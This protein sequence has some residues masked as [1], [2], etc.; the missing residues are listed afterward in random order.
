MVADMVLMK[1]HLVLPE[2]ELQPFGKAL[3]KKFR[4]FLKLQCNRSPINNPDIKFLTWTWLQLHPNQQQIISG[5]DDVKAITEMM[6]ALQVHPTTLK[7][8]ARPDSYP[9]Y[10][11]VDNYARIVHNV[12]P[13]SI[14]RLDRNVIGKIYHDYYS[15]PVYAARNNLA[16]HFNGENQTDVVDYVGEYAVVSQSS[17]ERIVLTKGQKNWQIKA[18]HWLWFDGD[19]VL[20]NGD[21]KTVLAARLADPNRLGFWVKPGEYKPYEEHLLCPE[22]EV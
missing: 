9:L 18:D 13:K 17:S 22:V 4:S 16:L 12:T 11:S 19:G 14:I 2:E 20:H 5:F 10:W 7:E 3:I 21:I 6:S 15:K 8:M 1:Q